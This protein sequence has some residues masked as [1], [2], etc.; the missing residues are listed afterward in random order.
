MK[1]V[2]WSKFEDW[3]CTACGECCKEYKVPLRTYE[4]TL[5]SNIFGHHCMELGVGTAYLKQRFDG[6]CIFQIRKGGKKLCGIQPIKPLACKMWPF[7]VSETPLHGYKNEAAFEFKGEPF[8]IYVNPF[9]RGLIYGRPSQRLMGL[10]LPEFVE[11]KLGLRRDQARSTSLL[12][13][14]PVPSSIHS[15]PEQL[16]LL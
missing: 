14:T 16:K 11:L 8:Y 7:I 13:Q 5:L 3:F 12:L 10:V 1:F 15:P 2:P 4:M 9:C 6:R